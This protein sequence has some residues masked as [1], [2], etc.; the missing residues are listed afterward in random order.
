M[1]KWFYLFLSLEV[2]SCG[3]GYGAGTEGTST[4][5]HG[6]LEWS[7]EI[8]IFFHMPASSFQ[9]PARLSYNSIQ[10]WYYLPGDAVKF[11]RLGAQS[12][13]TALFTSHPHF[14]CQSQVRVITCVSNQPPPSPWG[15]LICYCGSEY[16]GSADIY[17]LDICRGPASAGSRGYPQDEWRQR[18]RERERTHVRPALIGPSLQGRERERE[19]PDGGCRVWQSL[20]MLYFLP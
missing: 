13:R 4:V 20:A 6:L 7:P 16:C 5:T 11:C 18:E 17:F 14:R 15:Q 10:F 1:E 8:L 3:L 2:E 9:T 12:W 19:W